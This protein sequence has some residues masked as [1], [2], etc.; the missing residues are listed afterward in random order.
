MANKKKLI[1]CASWINSLEEPNMGYEHI[2]WELNE[3]GVGVLTMNRPKVF[4]AMS[5]RMVH[6]M[7]DVFAFIDR[8]DSVKVLVLTGS[9]DAFCSG[10]DQRP[11]KNV[12]V[13]ELF[14]RHDKRKFRSSPH[15]LSGFGEIAMAVNRCRIPVIAAVNGIAAGGG[16]SVSL[17]ADIRIA[18]KNARFC[19]VFMRRAQPPDTGTSYHL[20]RL[21]GTG[22]AMELIMTGDIIDAERA[23]TI[24]LVNYVVKSEELLIFTLDLAHRIASGPSVAIELAKKLVKESLRN[25]LETQVS[26]EAWTVS[27]VSDTLDRKEGITSFLEKRK[28]EFRGE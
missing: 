25:T 28:P 4:N 9:G 1:Q 24:G 7:L 17:G 22:H 3:D 26:F 15:G 8:D 14:D 19:S 12:D 16:L 18:S 23:S 13:F 6:E 2:I 10:A 27:A 11:D 21:V 20:P 5:Q